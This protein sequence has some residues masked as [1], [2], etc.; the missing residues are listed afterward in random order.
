MKMQELRQLSTNELE[1]KKVTLMREKFGLL[2]QKNS[3]ALKETHKL[4]N[5]RRELARLNTILTEKE[6]NE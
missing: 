2:L 4:R 3:R 5:I 6:N 1:A